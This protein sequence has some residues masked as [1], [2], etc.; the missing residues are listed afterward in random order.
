MM[1]GFTLRMCIDIEGQPGPGGRKEVGEEHVGVTNDLVEYLPCLGMLQGEANAP[2]SVVRVL[3]DRGKWTG[4]RYCPEVGQP[5]LGITG[6]GV[7]DLDDLGSPLGQ[8]G[9]GRGDKGVLRH[10][11]NANAFHGTKYHQS[12]L[13]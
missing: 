6:L 3:D 9:P 5:P 1:S 4:G 13:A 12:G 8:D 10:L 2:L 11:D 7:L